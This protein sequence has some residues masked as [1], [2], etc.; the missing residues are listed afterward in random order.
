MSLQFGI[1][2]GTCGKSEQTLIKE[3][4]E[5]AR[6]AKCTRCGIVRYCSRSCQRTDFN[7]HKKICETI[8]AV[9]DDL[10]KYLPKHPELNS[11]IGDFWNL[12]Q[13]K[14]PLPKEFLRRKMELS[15]N[16]WSFADKHECYEATELVL[17]HCLEILRFDVQDHLG[18]KIWIVWMFLHLGRD[19]DAYNFLKFWIQ[20]REKLPNKSYQNLEEGEFLHFKDQDPEEHLELSAKIPLGF[21]L[22]LLALKM[23]NVQKYEERKSKVEKFDE[24]LMQRPGPLKNC[25]NVI[26]C[27]HLFLMGNKDVHKANYHDQKCQV[28]EILKKIQNANSIILPALLNPKPLLEQEKL[29]GK[30]EAY[31]L[32]KITSKYFKRIPQSSK[33]TMI[34]FT[35]PN[36]EAGK[37][38]PQYPC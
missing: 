27:V 21:L 9:T 3:K 2:C 17:N 32:L 11:K 1:F 26:D 24:K 5:E 15:S 13:P 31:D 20:H 33:N 7:K 35:Y 4:G 36:H 6:L 19:D 25:Q 37:A 22:A 28:D 29:A 18:V 8:K 10:V 16:I 30:N 23:K 34:K 12:T 38:F 14:N